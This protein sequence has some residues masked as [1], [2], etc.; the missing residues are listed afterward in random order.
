M[1]RSGTFA[2]PRMSRAHRALASRARARA[3]QR[4]ELRAGGPMCSSAT[5]VVTFVGKSARHPGAN[6]RGNTPHAH[7]DEQHA[8]TSRFFPTGAHVL[9]ASPWSAAGSTLRVRF[10]DPRA[11]R[12][13]RVDPTLETLPQ[14]ASTFLPETVGTVV[15]PQEAGAHAI[16]ELLGRFG[17][18]PP[19]Q[20]LPTL[21]RRHD[22]T[23]PRVSQTTTTRW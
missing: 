4:A 3:R 5:S 23:K 9:F 7:A 12:V 15:C 13:A 19:S 6:A 18:G 17:L 20:S 16:S 2:W 8:C 1:R 21:A 14:R 22:R 10:V 11:S